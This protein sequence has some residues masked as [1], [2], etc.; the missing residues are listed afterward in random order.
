MYH[1]GADATARGVYEKVGLYRQRHTG[2]DKRRE[3]VRWFAQ[4]QSA[5]AQDVF[6]VLEQRYDFRATPC[7]IAAFRRSYAGV[8]LGL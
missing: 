7:F 2:H 6:L 4:R 8:R 3:S 1:P 5:Q